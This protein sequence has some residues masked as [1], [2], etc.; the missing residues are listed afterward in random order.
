MKRRRPKP[1]ERK[2]ASSG[3]AALVAHWRRIGPELERIRRQELRE[4]NYRE[5]WHVIDALLDAGYGWVPERTMSGLVELQR[6]L[7]KAQR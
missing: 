1:A 2:N 6:L 5:Q 7:A 4:F 3:I